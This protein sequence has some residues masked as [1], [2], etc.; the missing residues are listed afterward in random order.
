MPDAKSRLQKYSAP[1]LEKGLDILELLSLQAGKGLS[2]ADIA[3]GMGRSKNEIF[4]M[5]VVLEERGYIQRSSDD[6]FRLTSKFDTLF[7]GRTDAAR[8]LEIARPFMEQLSAQTSLSS[9]FW[10]L[11]DNRMQVALRSRVSEAYSL[12]LPEGTQRALF[13]SSVGACFLSEL[14]DATARAARLRDCGETVPD[15][16]FAAFDAQVDQ[17]HRDRVS[18]LH[19]PEANG[20]VEISAPITARPARGVVAALSIPM[21]S[22]AGLE[23]EI[24]RVVSQLRI[25]ADRI[26][27]RMMLLS[28]YHGAD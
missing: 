4:R 16:D 10:I 24:A 19:N 28:V 1:A 13:G 11:S 20:I 5:M 7:A 9:H 23:N 26:M 22:A 14:P 25:T 12:S 3:E 17:C 2:Q 18:V 21:I 8:L 27:D 15:A 6:Q